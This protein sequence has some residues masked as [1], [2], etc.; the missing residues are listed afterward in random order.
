MSKAIEI[1]A[2]GFLYMEDLKRSY[3]GTLR[4][5]QDKRRKLLVE[6]Q[7]RTTAPVDKLGAKPYRAELRRLKAD[8]AELF[9]AIADVE[10]YISNVNYAIE[11]MHT[12]RQPG[13]KRGVERRA[14]YQRNKLVDP[15]VLQAFSNQY[16]S[17]SSSTLDPDK[18]FQLEQALQMLSPQERDVYT[19]AH[20]HGVKQEDIA[21]MMGI[22]RNS[23]KTM[24]DRA[25]K[26]V[27]AEI[28]Q[29]VFL[30]I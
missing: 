15:L 16:N 19:M 3:R 5:L 14:A 6:L 4:M 29:N 7:Q 13:N 20:G 25:H 28:E 27:S 12:G 30:Q 24:I 2:D 18:A 21:S 10:W 1:D 26:K 22:S 23:V 11:W 8:N 9:D 17:R